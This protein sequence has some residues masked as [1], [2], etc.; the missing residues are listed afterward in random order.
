MATNIVRK[1]GIYRNGFS[2]K[3]NQ[4]FISTE[5]AKGYHTSKNTI[6]YQTN[7]PFIS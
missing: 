3:I 1:G 7:S 5:F 4:I 2:L 6:T